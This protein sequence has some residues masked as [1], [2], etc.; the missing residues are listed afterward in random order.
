MTLRSALRRSIRASRTRSTAA[1]WSKSLLN[2]VLF[3]AVFMVAL[4]GLAHRLVP[5]ALPIPDALR[6]FPAGVL[7]GVGI[8]AWLACLDVF[9]RRGRGTPL[10][11]D[12]PRNLV[13]GGLFSVV[14]NPI[15]AAEL[16]VIWAEALYLANLGV[17]LYAASISAAAHLLVVHVEEP[18]LRERFG[19]SY[20][21][22]CQKV[23]RWLPR[24]RRPVRDGH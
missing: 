15:M 24:M 5:V 6:V 12:A 14:R 9:S 4:P 20:E 8:L 2:A 11:M 1:L 7:F 17:L 21:R 22:Y 3:F 19:E 18:E 13:T 10:P 16:L 23:P